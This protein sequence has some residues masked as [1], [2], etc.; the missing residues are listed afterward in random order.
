MDCGFKH[1]VALT[2]EGKVYTWG[3]GREGELGHG[4]ETESALPRM[5]EALKEKKIVK[6]GAGNGYTIALSE[7]GELYSW[8][9]N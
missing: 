8:G 3:E 9:A 1:T 4:D 7:E 2:K 6:V 5:V